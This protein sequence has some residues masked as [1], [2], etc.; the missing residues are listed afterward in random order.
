MEEERGVEITEVS[1]VDDT[2]RLWLTDILTRRMMMTNPPA[3]SL[4]IDRPAVRQ[5]VG[6]SEMAMADGAVMHGMAWHGTSGRDRDESRQG[7][8]GGKSC[9]VRASACLSDAA[10]ERARRLAR[11]RRNSSSTGQW[12]KRWPGARVVD[13]L[14]PTNY[15]WCWRV[16]VLLLALAL[17]LLTAAVVQV[18]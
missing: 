2:T 4:H 9:I 12:R 5:A 10:K 14:S 18:K 1:V 15:C 7:V 8:T 6:G 16:L 17:S 11:P 3:V 13:A